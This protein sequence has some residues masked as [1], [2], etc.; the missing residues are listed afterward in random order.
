VA[1][2]PARWAGASRVARLA[3]LAFPETKLG[4][5]WLAAYLALTGFDAR[6]IPVS[7]LG[8]H[9]M[10]GHEADEERQVPIVARPGR[11]T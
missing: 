10:L 11:G 1:D 4:V 3:S 9:A 2:S 6:G 8:R 7:R 5:I